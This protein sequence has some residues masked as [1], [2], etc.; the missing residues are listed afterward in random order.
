MA[1]TRSTPMRNV[2]GAATPLSGLRAR[3]VSD[4][5]DASELRGSVGASGGANLV[6]ALEALDSMAAEIDNDGA[7]LLKTNGELADD[8]IAV[9]KFRCDTVSSLADVARE[10]VEAVEEAQRGAGEGVVGRDVHE[11]RLQEAAKKKQYVLDDILAGQERVGKLEEL[12]R[13]MLLEDK[14]NREQEAQ[15]KKAILREIPILE[16]TLRFHR[17]LSHSKL[18]WNEHQSGGGV[19]TGFVM[20][21]E[22]QH[23]IRFD[24]D[25]ISR[26]DAVN[27]LWEMI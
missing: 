6:D 14:E 16:K 13:Q 10:L 23:P 1:P 3:A 17:S 5:G 12:D 18:Y 19:L 8:M 22:D 9:Q 2:G 24:Y 7:A 25:E 20:V 4:S 15:R 11:N 21:K 26:F 27:K